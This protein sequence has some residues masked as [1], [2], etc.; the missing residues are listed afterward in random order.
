M[1]SRRVVQAMAQVKQEDFTTEV[2]GY[3]IHEL[4]ADVDAFCLQK[5]LPNL[6]PGGKILDVGCGSGYLTALLYELVKDNKSGL[7]CET[8][9]IAID[10]IEPMVIIAKKNLGIS[11]Q[12]EL[13]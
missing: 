6:R 8:S 1:P 10:N 11:Y 5:L 2:I 13:S 9:V 3:K 12:D 7:N 4:K